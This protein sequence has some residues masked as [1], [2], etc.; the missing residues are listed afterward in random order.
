[1][2]KGKVCLAMNISFLSRARVIPISYHCC[3]Q[4]S[5]TLTCSIGEG[6]VRPERSHCQVGEMYPISTP[7][8]PAALH[9]L[10]TAA[11]A[12]VH[13]GQHV[14]VPP[15]VDEDVGIL[16]LEVG[17]VVRLRQERS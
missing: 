14:V 2:G 10:R 6:D 4:P 17:E 7:R 9:P 8:V 16:G 3:V 15:R 12:R 13:V 11:M 1:M 5:P